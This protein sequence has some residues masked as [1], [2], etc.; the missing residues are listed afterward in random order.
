MEDELQYKPHFDRITRHVGFL[1]RERNFQTTPESL[2]EIESYLR[3]TFRESGCLVREETFSFAG[4][5]F[6][7]WIASFEGSPEKPRLLIGAHFDSVPG[8]PGAD[9]NASGVAALLES[10]RIYASLRKEGKL[11]PGS[12]EVALEFVAF[13]LEECGLIGSQAYAEK[14]KREA[15]PLVGMLSL[16]MI[17]YTSQ[18]KGSQKIPF[19]LKPFY[20]DVGNFVGLVANARSKAFLKRVETVFRSVQGLPVEAL[21]LP[22]NG[23][24]FPEA[25]R[26]DHSPFWDAGFPA[27][28]VTDT[29]FYRNPYYHSEEDRVETLDL[30]FLA[31]VTE[32]T[33]RLACEFSGR[34]RKG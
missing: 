7:N 25:R 13:N 33:T 20:P 10:A 2:A 28:L 9:D 4:E 15:V 3:E 8:S 17:G 31:K 27:L 24:V 11:P 18:E 21:V 1:A 32:A 26:S 29:S 19:F 23:W 12:E 22:A 16:E 14:L 34:S 30:D 6:S 5:T